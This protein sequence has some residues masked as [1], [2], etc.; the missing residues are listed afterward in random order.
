MPFPWKDRFEKTIFLPFMHISWHDWQ[1]T[2]L[3]TLLD[4]DLDLLLPFKQN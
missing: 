3:A 4:D 2:T 1:E